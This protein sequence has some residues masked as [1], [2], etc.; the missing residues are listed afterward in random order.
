MRRLLLCLESIMMPPGSFAHTTQQCA[1][2]LQCVL[3]LKG[4]YHCGLNGW[5]AEQ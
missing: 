4:R 5:K 3:S 1:V 2:S